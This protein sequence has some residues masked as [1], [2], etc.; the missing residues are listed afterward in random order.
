MYRKRRDTKSKRGLSEETREPV[1]LK[2]GPPPETPK[3]KRNLRHAADHG[4]MADSHPGSGRQQRRLHKEG[5]GVVMQILLRYIFIK[6]MLGPLGTEKAA[7]I[8]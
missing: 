8:S 7:H 2:R 5:G 1:Q 4:L 3:S 6:S